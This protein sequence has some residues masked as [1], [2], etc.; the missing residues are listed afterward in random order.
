MTKLIRICVLIVGL[1]L[2]AIAECYEKNTPIEEQDMM[3]IPE[4][5]K[6]LLFY[7]QR[8]PNKNTICY[9]LNFDSKGALV[10]E[11]PVHIFWIRYTENGEHKDL[12]FIQKKFAYGLKVKEIAK[13][14]YDLRFVSYDKKPLYLKK[15]TDGNYYVF[16]TI[17]GKP[18]VLR[19]IYIKID[20]G[21]FWSPNVLYIELKGQDVTTGQTIVERIKP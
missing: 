14:N 16:T 12:N 17:S 5:I 20:G 3:P 11:T 6:N 21:T 2:P 7:V 9:E 1:M 10:T 18:A 15:A 13:D 19:R 8:T 4:G